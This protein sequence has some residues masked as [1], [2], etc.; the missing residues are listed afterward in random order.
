MEKTSYKSEISYNFRLESEKQFRG[1]TYTLIIASVISLFLLPATSLIIFIL[2]ETTIVIFSIVTKQDYFTTSLAFAGCIIAFLVKLNL[3]Q[4]PFFYIFIGLSTVAICHLPIT[5]QY[6]KSRFPLLGKYGAVEGIYLLITILLAAPN[7]AYSVLY[8]INIREIGIIATFGFVLIYV[9]SGLFF[10][11]L[12]PNASKLQRITSTITN[13][14]NTT[15]VFWRCIIL[16]IIGE[17]C[18]RFLPSGLSSRLGQLVIL[19]GLLRL[20]AIAIIV[21]MWTEKR[22]NKFQS[23]TILLL[24]ACDTFFGF[25]GAFAL[26][27]II[28]GFK[29]ALFVITLKKRNIVIWILIL[30]IP[31]AIFM[32]VAKAEA[33]AQEST[34]VS[35]VS[36]AL[37]LLHFT[38]HAL[39]HAS[40]TEI[41]Q[42]A[43]RFNRA[44]EL[45]YIVYHVPRDYPYWNKQTYTLLPLVLIPR[46]IAP[47]K[48]TYGLQNEFGRKYGLLNPNDFITSQNLSVE[49]EAWANFGLPGLIIIGLIIGLLLAFMGSIFDKRYVDGIILGV[50]MAYECTMGLESGISS[51]ALALPF[52]IL[53][54]PVVR[55]ALISQNRA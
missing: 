51:F 9:I 32:N 54:I 14:H 47:F 20:V 34:N 46:F 25:S 18:R 55:W 37:S 27:S 40:K 29:V 5:L 10:E 43:E 44:K 49:V 48:P 52:V 7:D 21:F 41:E 38:N 3:S 11:Q 30:L 50:I 15:E 6:N 24:I 26:Y 28:G 45:G 4:L 31:V 19:L 17:Y 12:L 39:L 2:A 23:I 33:R 16:F 1:I 36:A 22:L 35:K 53:L 42:S 8:P 13:I